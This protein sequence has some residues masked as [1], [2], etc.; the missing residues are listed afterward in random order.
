MDDK[1]WIH[2]ILLFTHSCELIYIG[3]IYCQEM[4]YQFQLCLQANERQEGM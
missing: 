4:M 2:I 1:V 3:L